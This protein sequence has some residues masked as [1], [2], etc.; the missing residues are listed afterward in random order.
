MLARVTAST[1]NLAASKPTAQKISDQDRK[2]AALDNTRM[3]NAA[4]PELFAVSFFNAIQQSFNLMKLLAEEA[5]KLSTCVFEG[6]TYMEGER[7]NPQDH[8]CLKCICTKD[9]ENKTVT[10]NKDCVKI[11]C[12]IELFEAESVRDGCIPSYH[13]DSCCP[14]SWRCPTKSDAIIPGNQNEVKDPKSPKCKFGNL[15]LEIGDSLSA[16]DSSCSKCFCKN[17][18]MAEC[19]FTSC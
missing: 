10:E 19:T 8:K 9:F 16:D 2:L 12:N 1:K 4:P 3:T 5:K 11:S 13:K 6:K 7:M 14:Y 17:P 15:L 18:P